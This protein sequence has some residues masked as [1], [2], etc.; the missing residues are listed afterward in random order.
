[1]SVR[2]NAIQGKTIAEVAWASQEGHAVGGLVLTQRKMRR[3]VK[4]RLRQHAFSACLFISSDPPPSSIKLFPSTV[5]TS[6]ALP[7]NLRGPN[8]TLKI[9]QTPSFA[10]FCTSTAFFCSLGHCEEGLKVH[11]P[12]SPALMAEAWW[13]EGKS[14]EAGWIVDWN[15]W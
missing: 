11:D 9:T 15:T 8:P 7:W 10:A 6:S 4:T 5:E 2:K 14:Q 12:W 1:M 3:C 13:T